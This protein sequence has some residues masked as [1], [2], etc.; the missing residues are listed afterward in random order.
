M[1]NQ[2]N[3]SKDLMCLISG[4]SRI[5]IGVFPTILHLENSQVSWGSTSVFRAH[6]EAGQGDLD[7]MSN[8]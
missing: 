1:R 8:P 2:E 6:Q 3:V 7:P 4:I 5:D